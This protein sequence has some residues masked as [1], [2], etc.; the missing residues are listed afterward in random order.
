MSKYPEFLDKDVITY[1]NI[2]WFYI[3]INTRTFGHFLKY[4]SLVPIADM[5]NHENIDFFFYYNE[6]KKEEKEEKS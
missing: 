1:E 6:N 3:T 4:I 2:K 5:L